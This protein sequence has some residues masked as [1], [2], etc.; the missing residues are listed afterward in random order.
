MKRT[1][2]HPNT[3][4]RSRVYPLSP[5]CAKDGIFAQAISFRNASRDTFCNRSLMS[6]FAMPVFRS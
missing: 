2:S 3:L 5:P 6:S 4:K 1:N